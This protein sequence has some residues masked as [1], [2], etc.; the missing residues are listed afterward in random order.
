MIEFSPGVARRSRGLILKGHL[1]LADR[2][3]LEGSLTGKRPKQARKAAFKLIGYV[4]D[5]N[6]KTQL[7]RHCGARGQSAEA[8]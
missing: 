1:E 4:N 2:P 5:V 6:I 8:L 3:G 7:R